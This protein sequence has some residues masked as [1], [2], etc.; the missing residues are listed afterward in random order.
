MLQEKFRSVENENYVH[1]ACLRIQ[2]HVVFQMKTLIEVK[3]CATISPYT[4]E[5]ID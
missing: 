5:F 2:P 1:V 3:R 4:G